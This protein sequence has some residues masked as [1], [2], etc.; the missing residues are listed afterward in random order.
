MSKTS[1]EHGSYVNRL[2]GRDNPEGKVHHD[3]DS[4]VKWSLGDHGVQSGLTSDE[5]EEE[6]ERVDG[7]NDNLRNVLQ[8]AHAQI[9]SLDLAGFECPVCGLQHGHSDTKHD[10]RS[11]FNVSSEF[12]DTMEY[13]PYCH[14]GV[15]ELAVL[16]DFYSEFERSIFE[17]DDEFEAV[18][19]IRNDYVQAV[20]QFLRDNSNGDGSVTVKDAVQSFGW[21]DHI[22]SKHYD[23]LARFFERWI[24]IKNAANKAPIEQSTRAEINEIRNEL[25]STV[26][27]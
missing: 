24:D 10:I 7:I 22:P 16:I 2:L 9:Q 1:S 17:D 4:Q 13:V 12:A 3:E 6:I 11:G 23:D 15:N 18:S 5:L 25:A 8:D 14:C 27:Q 21:E 20:C 26:G 19:T